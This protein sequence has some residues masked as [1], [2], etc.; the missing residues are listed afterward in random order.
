[1]L[2][3]Y[4]LFI[5]FGVL[6]SIKPDFLVKGTSYYF[7]IGYDFLEKNKP[8]V[9]IF[10]RVYGVILAIAGIILLAKN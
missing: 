6:I 10:C 9:T 7:K 1:M 5:I 8:L 4:L 2:V 3:I